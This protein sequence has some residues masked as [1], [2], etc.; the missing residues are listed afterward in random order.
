MSFLRQTLAR[1]PLARIGVAAG[2]GVVFAAPL[3]SV[4][5]GPLALVLPLALVA[6]LV[7][8]RHPWLGVLVVLFF[9]PIDADKLPGP[10]A[11][12]SPTKLAGAACLAIAAFQFALRDRSI[13]TLASPLWPPLA[14]FLVLNI[15]AVLVSPYPETA[16]QEVQ[17]MAIA[18]LTF[19]LC[20]VFLRG[21]RDLERATAVV[22]AGLVVSA[23][24]G[25]TGFALRLEAFTIGHHEGTILRATGG[26][27]DPN[28][29]AATIVFGVPLCGVWVGHARSTAERLIALGVLSLLVMGV[30]LS[31]SR[32]GVLVL[33]A[34]L[35]LMMWRHRG[36]ITIR[37]LGLV[38]V[39]F[40]LA[41]VTV[42]SLAPDS[43]WARQASLFVD[44]DGPD[45][46]LQRRTSYLFVAADGVLAAP[47]LGHGTGTFPELYAR[48]SWAPR[49]A[50]VYN[51]DLYRQ[52]HN[53]YLEVVVGSGLAGLAVWLLLLGLTWRSLRRAD[54]MM[55]ARGD[56][57]RADLAE[58]WAIA[59]VSLLAHMM[60]LSL[61]TLKLVW[62]VVAM[63]SLMEARART[64][65]AALAGAPQTGAPPRP[66]PDP[67]YRL[68]MRLRRKGTPR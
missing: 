36:L 31:Q 52:A 39:G 46:S 26:L 57:L 27:S 9:I 45:R 51:P 40:C 3:A 53:T 48:S 43:F 62:A 56:P 11:S 13:T 29:F 4:S 50:T 12:L 49:F 42:I 32:G 14:L 54:R 8:L 17:D 60:I 25:V 15:L 41:T 6:G 68:L 66:R 23:F 37:R 19:V 61:L 47:L 2:L 24:L 34:T 59:L 30:V 35:G 55:R 1:Y 44:D 33:V 58:A 38:V 20:L 63:A 10:L 7:L 67:F 18:M 28:G 65:D 21:P 64:L 16:Q 22:L 5:Y